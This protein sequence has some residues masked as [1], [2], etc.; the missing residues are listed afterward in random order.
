MEKELIKLSDK[1]DISYELISEIIYKYFT[2]DGKN[3]LKGSDYRI[4]NNQRV[5]FINFAHIKKIKQIIEKEKYAIYPSDDLN[6]IFLFNDT[7]SQKMLEQKYEKLNNNDEI[8][9]FAKFKDNSKYEGYK[10]IG[11]FSLQGKVNKKPN[12]L[13]FKKIKNDFILRKGK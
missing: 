7:L 2:H 6:E 4:N 5:W 10:F 8:I 1:D 3:I 12:H 11:I 9:V 13:L